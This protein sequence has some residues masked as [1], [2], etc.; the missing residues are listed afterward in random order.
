MGRRDIHSDRRLSSSGLPWFDEFSIHRPLTSRMT[1]EAAT[2]PAVTI[3][4]RPRRF[5]PN[6]IVENP[7]RRER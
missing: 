6:V 4:G 3:L 5:R 1:T 7:E 2:T